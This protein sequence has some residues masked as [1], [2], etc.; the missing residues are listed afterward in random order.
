MNEMESFNYTHRNPKNVEAGSMI[1]ALSSGVVG[2]WLS[3][4]ID[5]KGR[6]YPPMSIIFNRRDNC[7]MFLVEDI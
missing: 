7:R 5:E 1:S 6:Y 3:G 4:K 2:A